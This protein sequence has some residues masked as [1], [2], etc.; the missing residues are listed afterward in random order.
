M[1][2][3]AR[4]IERIADLVKDKRI[5]GVSDVR[6]ESDRHDDIRVVVELRRDATPMVVLN[7]LTGIRSYRTHSA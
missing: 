1:V 6:D 5:E 7:Q 3:K 2:N 4:L